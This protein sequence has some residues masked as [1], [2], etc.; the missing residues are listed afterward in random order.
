MGGTVY[1][2]LV[3]FLLADVCHRNIYESC[4]DEFEQPSC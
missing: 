1:M 4:Y 3:P 2:P